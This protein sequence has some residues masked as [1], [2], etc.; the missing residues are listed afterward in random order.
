MQTHLLLM[1]SLHLFI[2]ISR[3]CFHSLL[4]IYFISSACLK[5]ANFPHAINNFSMYCRI[6]CSS[7]STD[8]HCL[9]RS[10]WFLFV[11]QQIIQLKWKSL[12]FKKSN[13]WKLWHFSDESPKLKHDSPGLLSMAIADRDIRGSLFMI[14]FN[15]LHHLDRFIKVFAAI[16]HAS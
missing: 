1:I 13:W 3:L 6:N 16:E 11:Q 8:D 15:A 14:T 12:N 2:L 10:E 9:F 5:K 4:L 7:F